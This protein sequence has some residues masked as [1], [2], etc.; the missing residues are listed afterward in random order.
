MTSEQGAARHCE[1]A[2]RAEEAISAAQGWFKS[3][4]FATVELETLD[5]VLVVKLPSDQQARLLAD[6][7]LRA[8]LVNE[9]QALGFKRVAL[10][11]SE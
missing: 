9:G 10:N 3:H 7:A 2:Q 11:I 5:R 1:Q 8:A 4:G 6:E